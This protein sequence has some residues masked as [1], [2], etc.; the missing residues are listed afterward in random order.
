MSS[1]D[2]E[3]SLTGTLP[4]NVSDLGGLSAITPTQTQMDF[5][6]TQT[7]TQTQGDM[8]IDRGEHN[9]VDTLFV[10][11]I[12]NARMISDVLNTLLIEKNITCNFIVSASGIRIVAEGNSGMQ[13][14]TFL[15][16]DVFEAFQYNS[17]ETFYQFAVPLKSFLGCLTIYGKSATARPP[18][19]TIAYKEYGA[20]LHIRMNHQDILTHCGIRTLDVQSVHNYSDPTED[21]VFSAK[22]KSESLRDA[23][24]ELDWSNEYLTW[25]IT[26]GEN[27]SLKVF[28]ISLLKKIDNRIKPQL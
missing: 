2:H 5:G 16:M 18:S 10:C 13:A 8:E 25:E 27:L 20:P 17:E 11:K 24:G 15:K 26:P 6:Q 4:D 1:D 12:G 21:V 14:M 7:Q 28:I 23:F 19:L 9:V 22:M 3:Y